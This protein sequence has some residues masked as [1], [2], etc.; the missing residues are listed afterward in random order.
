MMRRFQYGSWHIDA[1][2]IGFLMIRKNFRDEKPFP[3]I[4]PVFSVGTQRVSL[5]MTY[6]P[7]I[8][9]KAVALVFFQLKVTLKNL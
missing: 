6:I 3:G 8:E 4:L 9:P 2:A 5:N 7:K 1:G